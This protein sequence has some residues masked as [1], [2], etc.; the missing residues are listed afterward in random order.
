MR[1]TV[2]MHA[3]RSVI[4]NARIPSI[5]IRFLLL[6]R[7][8]AVEKAPKKYGPQSSAEVHFGYSTFGVWLNVYTAISC[9]FRFRQA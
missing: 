6:L 2:W 3:V 1:Y 7:T 5:L 8:A 4:P 9:K